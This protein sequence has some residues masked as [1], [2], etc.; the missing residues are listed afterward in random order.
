MTIDE[1]RGLVEGLEGVLTLQPHPGD[2]TPEIS[3]GDLFIYYAP[4]GQVPKTQPFATIVTKDYP[5]DQESQLDRP[6]TFRVNV[7]AGRDAFVRLAGHEPRAQPPG[8]VD[9]SAEDTVFAHP[10]Y[11]ELGW[12]AVV[13]PGSQTSATVAELLR[14]AHD[15]ARSRHLRRAEPTP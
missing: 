1:I 15:L 2:G 10:V 12:L 9:P 11:G 5:G 6:D 7:A 14:A 8:P 3:W 13:N 4:D